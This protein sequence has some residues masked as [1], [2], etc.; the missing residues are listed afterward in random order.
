MRMVSASVGAAAASIAA[1]NRAAI[2]LF[3][4]ASSLQFFLIVYDAYGFT[5]R[6]EAFFSC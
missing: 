4:F 3:T 2:R 5:I 1:A 6:G